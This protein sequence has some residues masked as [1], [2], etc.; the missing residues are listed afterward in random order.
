MS[1]SNCNLSA[2]LGNQR[3]PRRC[4]RKV[5]RFI[6]DLFCSSIISAKLYRL[7]QLLC[8][9]TS[10]PIHKF[11]FRPGRGTIFI[12]RQEQER[13]LEG[14]NKS[15]CTFVDLEKFIVEYASYQRR[16]FT[17]VE[18]IRC[19]RKNVATRGIN[20]IIIYTHTLGVVGRGWRWTASTYSF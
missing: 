20:G 11:G 6:T 17:R 3:L 4:N 10:P 19:C 1:V 12:V 5:T 15:S 14:N 2:R 13:L 7:A 16:L 18:M 8:N 9:K